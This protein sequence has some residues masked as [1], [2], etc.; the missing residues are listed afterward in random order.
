[1]TMKNSYSA[2]ATSLETIHLVS[3]CIDDVGIAN[4]LKYS[5]RLKTLRY[6]HKS[7]QNSGFQD[8]NI[9]NFVQA[10]GRE[11]GSHLEG[12]SISI[13]DLRRPITIGNVRISMSSFQRLRKLE[14]PLEIAI[15]N[16][17]AV[18]ASRAV[19][20]FKELSSVENNST[21]DSPEQKNDQSFL[22]TLVPASVSQLSL[23]SKGTTDHEKILEVLFRDFVSRKTSR[24][25]CL[26]T[27][28]LTCPTNADDAYKEQCVSLLAK[29][30][31]ADVALKLMPWS[32]FTT[33]TWDEES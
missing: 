17:A 5:S 31:K 28:F 22:D 13:C 33:I 4:F 27:I 11:A 29:T 26:S 32:V 3:C 16:I 12:L 1:M 8:W 10:I 25:P 21:N 24:L 20:V 18:A 9:C 2:F 6:S 7:K 15:C 23:I 14:L 19:T 30:K